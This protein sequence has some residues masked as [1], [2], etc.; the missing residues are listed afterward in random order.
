[1][2]VIVGGPEVTRD[3]PWCVASPGVDL[4]VVGEGEMTLT[5]L[6]NAVAEAKAFEPGCQVTAATFDHSAMAR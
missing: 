5:E 2:A 1:M 4:G 3:N 6:D